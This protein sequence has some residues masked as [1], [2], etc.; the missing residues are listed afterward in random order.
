ML[1]LIFILI[2]Q[3]KLPSQKKGILNK[4]KEELRVIQGGSHGQK[5]Q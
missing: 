3:E 2:A 5:I 1:V 4:A